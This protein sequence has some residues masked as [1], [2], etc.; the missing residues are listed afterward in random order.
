MPSISRVFKRKSSRDLRSRSNSFEEDFQ[1]L[2][3]ERP[4]P[5]LPLPHFDGTD[6]QEDGRASPSSLSRIFKRKS[7]TYLHSRSNSFGDLDFQ[8]FEPPPP[9]PPLPQLHLNGNARQ[10]DQGDHRNILGN[11]F[12][13]EPK[14]EPTTFEHSGGPLSNAPLTDVAAVFTRD[15]LRSSASEAIINT[16]GM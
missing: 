10:A 9:V 3:Q 15:P 12:H 11:I 6:K 2:T 1:Y 5:P 13:A 8:H 16:V 7:S 4:L 14:Q